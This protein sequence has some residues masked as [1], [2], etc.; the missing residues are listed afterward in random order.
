M[1]PHSGAETTPAVCTAANVPMLRPSVAAGDESA[2]AA[3]SSGVVN[4]LQMPCAARAATNGPSDVT[5][6]A[7]IDVAA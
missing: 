5:N 1:P 7:T 4:A 6:A 3:S 2:R